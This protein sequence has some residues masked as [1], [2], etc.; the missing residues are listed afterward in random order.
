MSCWSARA[1]PKFILP[2][3][4]AA[5]CRR[6]SFNPRQ[7]PQ[8]KP[9]VSTP[10]FFLLDSPQLFSGGAGSNGS[11]EVTK[12]RWKAGVSPVPRPNPS[13]SLSMRPLRT[14]SSVDAFPKTTLRVNHTSVE[15]APSLKASNRRP[16]RS[17]LPPSLMGRQKAEVAIV[18]TLL[19][20]CDNLIGRRASS[21][22]DDQ[23][24]RHGSH[25]GALA[26]RSETSTE[27]VPGRG[28]TTHRLDELTVVNRSCRRLLHCAIALS[29]AAASGLDGR[30][31][32]HSLGPGV[33]GRSGLLHHQ[34]VLLHPHARQ[35]HGRP[36]FRGETAAADVG[37]LSCRV[38]GR[39]PAL[40]RAWASVLGV[41]RF[42]VAGG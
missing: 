31:C 11:G 8:S 37:V 19:R 39:I 4:K 5:G 9:L 38:R 18:G 35:R 17:T 29:H 13:V 25:P 23:I 14:T 2:C 24:P 42:T 27:R 1:S 32:E 15:G 41:V 12:K 3:G 10:P 22:N 30:R 36:R 20:T 6:A 34:W 21:Y 40:L 33:S 26:N 16:A 28:R 7:S